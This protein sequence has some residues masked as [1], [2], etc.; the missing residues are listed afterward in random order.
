M[1]R[2]WP[3]VWGQAAVRRLRSKR[4]TYVCAELQGVSLFGVHSFGPTVSGMYYTP[5]WRLQTTHEAITPAFAN[6]TSR[7]FSRL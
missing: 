4:C 7:R 5:L 3:I 2:W 1:R 6:K